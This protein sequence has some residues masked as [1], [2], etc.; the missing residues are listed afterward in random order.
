VRDE[1]GAIVTDHLW[2]FVGQQF[3]SLDLAPG[4][5]VFFCARV[6]KYRK[7]NP[8]VMDDEDP[9][10]VEDYRL[11]HPSRV[12]KLGAALVRPMPLFDQ[13]PA[14]GGAQRRTQP[15]EGEQA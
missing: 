9:Q 8:D 1:S 3:G 4:D 10:F 6:T 11:S 7:R 12:S 2:F 5:E 13:A 14:A 15:S